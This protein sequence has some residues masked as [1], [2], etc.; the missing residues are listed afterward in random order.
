MA[1]TMKTVSRLASTDAS[2]IGKR[3]IS[4]LGVSYRG[5][6]HSRGRPSQKGIELDAAAALDWA[7]KKYSSTT[8][9]RIVLWG[10]SIGSGVALTAAATYRELRPMGSDPKVLGLILETP[11]TNLSNLLRDFYPQK[12]LPYRYLTPFLRSHWDSKIALQRIAEAPGDEKPKLLIL[13]ASKDEVV[14]GKHGEELE[15]WGKKLNL[16]IERRIIQGALHTEI[17]AK[18]AGREEIARYL[19]RFL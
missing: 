2:I 15:G 7:V 19:L 10:E 1:D 12:W 6:W 11:F 18:P 14:P 17:K 16:D 9:P 4:F 5:F 8:R 3:K 13:Q